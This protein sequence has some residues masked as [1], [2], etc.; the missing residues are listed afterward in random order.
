MRAEVTAFEWT[1]LERDGHNPTEVRA[2]SL[3][4]IARPLGGQGG[5][6]FHLT[7]C[8]PDGLTDLLARDGV[9]IGRHFLFV[10]VLDTDRVEAVIRDRLRR[11]DG[12]SWKALAEKI[13]R[14]GYWEFEDYTEVR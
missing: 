7:V 13:G 5:E 9:V 11:L 3:V 4:F 12:D 2:T 10:P 14:I 6:T 8:T 1:D